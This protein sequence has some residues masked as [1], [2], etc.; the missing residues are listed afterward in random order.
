MFFLKFVGFLLSVILSGTAPAAAAAIVPKDEANLKLQVSLLSDV[1]MQSFELSGFQELTK[2][3]LDIG[4]SERP[5]DALVFAGDNTMNGQNFEY[6]MFYGLLSKYNP[7]K[8]TST[9]VVMGNH[10]FMAPATGRQAMD[11]HSFFYQSYA[12]AKT[13]G[14]VYCQKI[15]GYMFIMLGGEDEHD[16][17]VSA[18]YLEGLRLL[19]AVLEQDKPVFV[20]T[21][22]P[23]RDAAALEV[24]A[25]H[26][27]VFLFNGHWHTP[28]HVKAEDGITRVNLPALHSHISDEYA[29][30][31][32]QMEVYA[33]RVIFR[34]RNYFTGEWGREFE[35]AIS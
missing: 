23:L 14:P 1:H 11:R 2:A 31:G 30:E 4:A 5:Q 7:V 27:H 29:G 21:H 33:D 20:F 12:G 22:Y 3:L 25:R 13:D 18:A 17:G 28:L 24:L 9:M 15:N 10:D 8:N 26:P 34:Q 6:L 19:L 16:E 32:V 35:V